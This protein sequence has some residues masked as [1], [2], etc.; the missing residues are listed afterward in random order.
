[1]LLSVIIPT[2]NRPE[3]L[4]R[5]IAALR[6]QLGPECGLVIVDNCS[7]VPVCD[8]LADDIAA[9]L[10]VRIHRN[11]M[12]VGL[13]ANLCRCFEWCET[14]WFWLLG[15]DD[16]PYPDA[17]AQITAAIH[18]ARKEV[19]FL[20]FSSG[21]YTHTA[22]SSFSTADEFWR[23]MDHGR[24]MGNLLFMSSGVYRKEPFRS[25]HRFGYNFATSAAPHLALL[26]RVFRFGY[27]GEVRI[28]MIAHWEPPP[29]T[30]R[31]AE[32][33]VSIGLP[34]LREVPGITPAANQAIKIITSFTGPSWK[35]GLRLL[36]WSDVPGWILVNYFGRLAMGAGGL[37]V[38]RFWLFWI[39]AQIVRWIPAVRWFLMRMIRMAGV[40]T[41]PFSMGQGLNRI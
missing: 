5:T 33:M 36:F 12:N 13:S 1:M 17:V 15:D 25:E 9:G 3:A 40:K 14:P 19:C 8:V 16:E 24:K 20:N 38:I 22:N 18:A 23:H 10:P 39:L 41:Q 2:Y 31:W 21:I 7:D 6:P 27:V 37:A 29:A 30:E 28:P 26:I 32:M 4:R 35:R 11:A 34:L